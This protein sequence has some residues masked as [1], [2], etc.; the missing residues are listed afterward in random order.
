MS[1]GLVSLSL[2]GSPKSQAQETCP[3]MILR[4]ADLRQILGTALGSLASLADRY[5][6][7]VVP[8]EAS[9][10]LRMSILTQGCELRACSTPAL[11]GTRIGLQAFDV[12]G[13][14]P[15]FEMLGVSRRVPEAMTD[16]DTR[17]EAHCG[18]KGFEFL[19]ATPVRQV[20]EAVVR[21]QFAK[22]ARSR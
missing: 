3:P 18:A 1:V 6:V 9:C 22:A 7:E 2:F 12:A 21:V 15:V 10:Y 20:G 17:I 19:S 14:S 4:A 8:E 11:R 13:C 5:N 16:A